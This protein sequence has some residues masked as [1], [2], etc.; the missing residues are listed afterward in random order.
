MEPPI[1][2]AD[3]MEIFTFCDRHTPEELKRL[4][5]MD[6]DELDQHDPLDRRLRILDKLH[7]HVFGVPVEG[8]SL[9]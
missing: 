7:E 6:D 3:F 1:S 8:C 4:A 9:S 2:H 5:G